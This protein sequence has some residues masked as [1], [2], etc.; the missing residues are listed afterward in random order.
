MAEIQTA[1]EGGMEE[2][3]PPGAVEAFIRFAAG[4]E[5]FESLGPRLRE[6]MPGDGETLFGETSRWLAESLGVEVVAMP[7]ARTPYFDRPEEM[8][9]RPPPVSGACEFDPA[10]E[11]V[12]PKAR[13]V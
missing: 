4:D 13:A 8:A 11:E 10:D 9:D 1:V 6:R 2:E 12:M 5:N 3:A 7:G